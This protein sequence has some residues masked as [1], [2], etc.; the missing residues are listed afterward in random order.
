MGI[1]YS[2]RAVLDLKYE[3]DN[4]DYLF[5]KCLENN[6]HLYADSFDKLNELDSSSAANRILSIDLECEDRCANAK[7]QD[8]DFFIRIFKKKNNLIKFSIGGFGRI[9]RR[10]FINDHY[11]ID[12]ARYIRL[13]LRICR[14]FTILALETDTF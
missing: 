12:F 11:G 7:F 8:T 13:L 4:I 6:I 3:K 1:I 2:V 14:D 10:E 9:W 5:Q